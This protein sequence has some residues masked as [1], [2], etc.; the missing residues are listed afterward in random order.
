MK[1]REYII[2]ALIL[3]SICFGSSDSIMNKLKITQPNPA[4]QDAKCLEQQIT[5]KKFN[6]ELI[7]NSND[8]FLDKNLPWMS[9]LLVGFATAA[10]SWYI[11][12]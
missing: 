7:L 10:A 3:N 1:T 2:L 12:N 8:K 6:G 5:L 4:I 9:A 11:G